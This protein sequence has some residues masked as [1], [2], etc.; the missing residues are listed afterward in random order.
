MLKPVVA[1]VITGV[2][3]VPAVIVTDT[4][5][6]AVHPLVVVAVTVYIPLLAN[7]LEAVVGLLPPDQAYVLPPLTVRSTGPQ[8]VGLPVELSTGVVLTVTDADA[9]AV[10]PLLLVTVTVYVPLVV[11]VLLAVFGLL[12]PDQA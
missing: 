3:G 5:L 8:F 11:N 10:H 4:A 1:P 7:V 12:P 6:E 2:G 9:V